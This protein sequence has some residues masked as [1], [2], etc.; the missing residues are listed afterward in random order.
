[1]PRPGHQAAGGGGRPADVTGAVQDQVTRNRREAARLAAA[2]APQRAR[3]IS[4]SKPTSPQGSGLPY[5]AARIR[6]CISEAMSPVA[7]TAAPSAGLGS[8]ATSARAI[9]VSPGTIAGAAYTSPPRSG[10]SGA[11]T[12]EYQLQTRSRVVATSAT[13]TSSTARDDPGRRAA[14]A[15]A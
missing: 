2:A 4:G 14:P 12:R 3:T 7:Q 15:S 5:Q 1:W 6:L 11:L 8:A 9:S 10:S 13:S